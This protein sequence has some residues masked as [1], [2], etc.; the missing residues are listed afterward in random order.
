MNTLRDLTCDPTATGH[1]SHEN[2]P[3]DETAWQLFAAV[4]RQL[5]VSAY[6]LCGNC[7]AIAFVCQG[8]AI[9][10][11]CGRPAAVLGAVNWE[12]EGLCYG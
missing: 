1:Q 4:K 3:Y 2:A 9:N 5:L 6:I 7:G 12:G 8:K 10:F 11:F